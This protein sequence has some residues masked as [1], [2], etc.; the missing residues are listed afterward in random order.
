MATRYLKEDVMRTKKVS[1][2]GTVLWC[3]RVN[4]ETDRRARE[5]GKGLGRLADTA[6]AEYLGRIEERG[7]LQKTQA[8]HDVRYID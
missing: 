4:A 3:I 7:Q 6:I 2:A 8:S 5:Y 1:T